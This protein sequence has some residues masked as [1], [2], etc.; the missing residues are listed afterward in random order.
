M[1]TLI[2]LTSEPENWVPQELEKKAKEKGFDVQVINP[3]KCFITLTDNP[4]IANDGKRFTGADIVIPRLSEDNL[5][6]KV[7]IINHLEKM[8]VKVINTGKSLR[9]ASNKV[10]TQILLNDADLKT[11]KTSVFTSEEQLPEALKAIGG[12][13]PVIIK[14]LFGTHGVGVVRADSNASLVSIVQQLLKSGEQFMLQ[15]YIE[16]DESARILLLDGKPIATVM[17]TIPDGDFRS[18]A[19][20]GAELKVHE[21]SEKELE[22]CIKAA[23]KL[24]IRLAAVDYILHNDEVILLEVNGSPGFE[25]MQKVVDEDIASIIIDFCAK[26]IG[27]EP[28][29]EEHEENETPEEEHEEHETPE[30]EQKEHEDKVVEVPAHDI[31]GDKV[32]GTLTNV[33]I[34]YFNDEQPIEARVDTGANLSSI[35]G[36]DIEVKD[37]TVKFTFGKTRYKFHLSKMTNIKQA[38]AEE[39]DERPVIRVDMVIDGITLRNVQLTVSDREHMA[40][41]VLLG[42]QT[43]AAGGFL[44]SPAIGHATSSDNEENEVEKEVEPN[45]GQEEE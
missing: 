42:R 38:S 21:P 4:F 7:A 31:E 24:G 16:H 26:E 14:T 29:S 36:E 11:P 17:R 33:V 34:K 45:N 39:S 28:S 3:D 12:T 9:L 22:A 6:Y 44:V 27:H 19:H 23:D 37:N 41:E 30:E 5:D 2:L 8:G 40:F 20:Q 35:H 10:E 25:A 43:L 1:T 13:F 18:N 32:I 15:E